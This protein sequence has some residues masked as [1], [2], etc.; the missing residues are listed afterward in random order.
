MLAFLFFPVIVLASRPWG[1]VSAVL[2][3]LPRDVAAP[4]VLHWS[5]GSGP[6]VRFC[7][8][9]LPNGLPGRLHGNHWSTGGFFHG[10]GK[11]VTVSLLLPWVAPTG[12]VVPDQ[13]CD[14]AS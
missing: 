8:L 14:F 12:P 13:W 4:V 2:G 3:D 10:P 7:L 5:R 11:R 9:G 6:V 1:V